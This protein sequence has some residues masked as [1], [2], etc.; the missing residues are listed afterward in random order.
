MAASFAVIL[1]AVTKEAID[2]AA[3]CASPKPAKADVAI[4]P[5]LPNTAFAAAD[6]NTAA[7]RVAAR[8][9]VTF[10]L[11]AEPGGGLS[12]DWRFSVRSVNIAP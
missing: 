5:L 8:I 10:K 4:K 11:K 6:A 2:T 12:G 3:E 9:T 1:P 7:V